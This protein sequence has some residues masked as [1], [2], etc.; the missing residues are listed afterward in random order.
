MN[1][2]DALAKL[3]PEHR[4]AL[5]PHVAPWVVRAYRTSERNAAVKVALDLM[6]SSTGTGKALDL[7]RRLGRYVGGAAWKTERHLDELPEGAVALDVAIHRL[8]RLNDG[9]P[10]RWRRI[11]DIAVITAVHCKTSLPE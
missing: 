3:P 5:L 7:E 8:A 4:A 2:A 1:P 9:Q 10:L 11:L 6:P